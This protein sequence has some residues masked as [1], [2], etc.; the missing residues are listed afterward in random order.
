M[1]STV[2]RESA[3]RCHEACRICNGPCRFR[4]ARPE[5]VADAGAYLLS[6]GAASTPGAAL[7]VDGGYTVR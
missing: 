3:R 1:T 2:V 5:E 4:G 6:P 7:V